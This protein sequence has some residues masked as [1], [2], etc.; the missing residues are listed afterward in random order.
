MPILQ[1][2]KFVEEKPR[3]NIP[4]SAAF[5]EWMTSFASVIM[6]KLGFRV[7]LKFV[8]ELQ[9][10]RVAM[11]RLCGGGAHRVGLQVNFVHF[12]QVFGLMIALKLKFRPCE[13][14][15]SGRTGEK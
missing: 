13:V 12:R 8:N 2:D 4:R 15:R 9:Q 6:T 3:Q 5:F 10:L 1:N 14:R 7:R 11:S